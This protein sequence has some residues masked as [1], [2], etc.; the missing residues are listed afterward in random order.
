MH[1]FTHQVREGC[2]IWCIKC[3]RNASFYASSVGGMPHFTH[4]VWE[5]RDASFYASSVR[6]MPHFTHQVSEGCLI[7]GIQCERDASFFASSARVVL[8]FE[9]QVWQECLIL[10]SAQI[11]GN[12]LDWNANLE[13]F[14]RSSPIR[15]SKPRCWHLLKFFTIF[16]T[17]MLMLIV[18]C[19]RKESSRF[20]LQTK[21]LTTDRILHLFLKWY[22]HF[23]IF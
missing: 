14:S 17:E 3:E 13:P 8:H 5:G 12:V 15:A 21:D 2:L 10:T 22:H 19:I 1:H 20:K 11:L 23:D 16:L 18:V 9:P 6:G 4:H 7:F